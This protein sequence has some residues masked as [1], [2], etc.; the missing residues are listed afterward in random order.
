[1]FESLSARL[2]G[3]FSHLRGRGKLTEANI[4][5]ATRE[6]R[7]ALLEADVNFQVVKDFVQRVREQALGQDV[8]RSLTPGQQVVKIV[9]DELTALMGSQHSP[10]TMAPQP[11]TTFLLVGLPGFR[12]DH[13]GGQACREIAGDGPAPVAGGG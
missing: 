8:M 9:R 6:I 5:E 4:K 13:L 2:N 1:M 10:I 11:P 12:E 7:L 3:I